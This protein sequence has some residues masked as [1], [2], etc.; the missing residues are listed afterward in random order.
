MRKD[1]LRWSFEKIVGTVI[2]DVRFDDF[3]TGCRFTIEENVLFLRCRSTHTVADRHGVTSLLRDAVQRFVKNG[4]CLQRDI[5][6]FLN[7]R[8]IEIADDLSD[9]LGQRG[10][11]R[12]LAS[13]LMQVERANTNG[14]DAD[15]E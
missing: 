14:G 4:G 5:G 13:V 1:V 11:G 8:Q 9:A 10:I 7:D 3:E 2:V 6:D 12:L 15:A